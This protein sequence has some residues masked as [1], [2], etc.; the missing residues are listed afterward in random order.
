MVCVRKE[1]VRAI[2]HQRSAAH[3]TTLLQKFYAVM[4]M[5]KLLSS[6]P[7]SLLPRSTPLPSL[8]PPSQKRPLLRLL[9]APSM[10]AGSKMCLQYAF[11]CT[12]YVCALHRN[13]CNTT[14]STL[15]HPIHKLY[16]Y[17]CSFWSLLVSTLYAYIGF[18]VDWWALGV[19]LYEMLAGRS[20]FDI[21]GA[22]E[23]PDQ[24]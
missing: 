14:C 12:F 2:Q 4:T 10:C 19:L 20:P 1:Y 5:V 15:S 24:V 3:Q 21:A 16:A 23:N 18:S 9:R 6:V 13:D 7:S 22:S 11:G 8:P 17:A